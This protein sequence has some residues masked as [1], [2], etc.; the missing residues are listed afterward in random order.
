MELICLFFLLFWIYETLRPL[1]TLKSEIYVIDYFKA[2]SKA[3][4]K[5]QDAVNFIERSLK[6]EFE[7]HKEDT[8]DQVYK[9]FEVTKAQEGFVIKF[10][11]KKSPAQGWF[12]LARDFRLHHKG[13]IY[14]VRSNPG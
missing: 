8:R 5:A 6:E 1:V 14:Q 12:N 2:T 4:V 10:K 9:I 7:K 3:F 13:T 11:L